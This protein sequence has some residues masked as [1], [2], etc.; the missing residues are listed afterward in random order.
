MY[1]ISFLGLCS[2]KSTKKQN[3]SFITQLKKEIF[4]DSRLGGKHGRATL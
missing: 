4:A 3:T 1:V 2:N